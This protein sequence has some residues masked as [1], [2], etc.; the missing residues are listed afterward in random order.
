MDLTEPVKQFLSG[1]DNEFKR[2]NAKH[3][4]LSEKLEKYAHR[5][6]LPPAD[7][8]EEKRLKREKL[9]LKDQMI[10]IADK[11]KTELARLAS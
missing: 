10:L 2:L 8:E 3:H 11:Y 1:K 4:E 7:Q 6:D 5:A 9:A